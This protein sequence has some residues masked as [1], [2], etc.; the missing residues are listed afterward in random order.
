MYGANDSFADSI[1]KQCCRSEMNEK[2]L[3]EQSKRITELEKKLEQL[4][5]KGQ[6][7]DINE[8][9][10]RY[11]EQ[12]LRLDE[13]ETKLEKIKSAE[14]EASRS[15][16]EAKEEVWT[17][18]VSK[19]VDKEIKIVNDKVKTVEERLKIREEEDRQKEL[20]KNNIIIHRFAESAIKED[21]KK[22]S[23]DRKAVISLINDVLKVPCKDKDIKKIFRL[24]KRTDTERPLLIEFQEGTMKNAVLENLS[25]L[26]LA[27]ERYKKISVTHDMTKNEREQCRELVKQCKEKASKEESGEW[28]FKVRG[29]PGAMRIVK[30]KKY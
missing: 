15:T 30:M 26:R 25:K 1:C 8:D 11:E 10:T 23:E 6:E 21:E 28:M 12:K 29:P 4:L 18:I 27:E 3:D 22:N 9:T 5:N 17:K 2:R 13:L 7:N 24:G 20:K 19:K 16:V 14:E